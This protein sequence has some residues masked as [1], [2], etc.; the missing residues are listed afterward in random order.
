MFEN[1]KPHA[2]LQEFNFDQMYL[3][4][5]ETQIARLSDCLILGINADTFRGGE[6]N[7]LFLKL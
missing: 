1:R 4:F 5:S 3:R 7:S 2:Q 6:G